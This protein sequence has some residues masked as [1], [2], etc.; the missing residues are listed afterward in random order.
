MPLTKQTLSLKFEKGLN[1][2]ASDRTL[3]VPEM[4]DIQNARFEKTGELRRRYGLTPEVSS[5]NPS[6]V[7]YSTSLGSGTE[8][9]KCEQVATYGDELLLMDGKNAYGKLEDGSWVDKGPCDPTIVRND[10]LRDDASMVQS[11]AD[12]AYTATGGTGGLALMGAAYYEVDPS[13][14]GK[15]S[16]TDTLTYKIY[17]Q[18]YDYASM[19]EFGE[20]LE[21]AEYTFQ[22][23]TNW[24]NER[25]YAAPRVRLFAIGDKFVVIYNKAVT[26]SGPTYTTHVRYRVIDTGESSM[27]GS[28]LPS[29]TTSLVATGKFAAWDACAFHRHA[30]GTSVDGIAIFHRVDTGTNAHTLQEY[31]ISGSNTLTTSAGRSYDFAHS[32]YAR[33]T[34]AFN[35]GTP[36]PYGYF[37]RHVQPRGPDDDTNAIYSVGFNV[38]D[39]TVK[40]KIATI[41]AA[42]ASLSLLGSVVAD[43]DNKGILNGSAIHEPVASG[44]PTHIRLYYTTLDDPHG[45]SSVYPVTNS[46]RSMRVQL[47]DGAATEKNK[48]VH[49]SGL[50]SDPWVF[51][52][53]IYYVLAETISPK[54]EETSDRTTPLFTTG[55]TYV[56]RDTLDDTSAATYKRE[57]ASLVAKTNESD[58][59]VTPY[60]DWFNL[61]NDFPALANGGLGYNMFWGCSPVIQASNDDQHLIG[62]S[63]YLGAHLTGDQAIFSTSL[64]TVSHKPRRTL[65][66]VEHNEQLL[67]GGG[68]LKSYSGHKVFENGFLRRPQISND[69]TGSTGNINGVTG[70]MESGTYYYR[71]VYEY[72]DEAGNLHR[73]APSDPISTTIGGSVTNGYRTIKVY[74]LVH[75]LRHKENVR[76]VLYRTLLNQ[77]NSFRVEDQANDF[78][79]LETTFHDIHR[80]ID[81]FDAANPEAA[82]E[83]LYTAGAA[84]VGSPGSITDLAVHKNRVVLAQSDDRVVVTKPTIRTVACEPFPEQFFTFTEIEGGTQKIYGIES[85]GDHLVIFSKNSLFAVSGEGPDAT[86]GGSRFSGARLLTKGQGAVEG[87]IHENTPAGIIYQSPRG[88]YLLKRGL[89]VDYVGASVEDLG[90]YRAIGSITNDARH[91]VY[92]VLGP[93][94]DESADYTGYSTVLVF[95]YLFGAWTQYTYDKAYVGYNSPGAVLHQGDI[96]FGRMRYA[97]AS[98]RSDNYAQDS[99]VKSG[100]WKEDTS[101]YWDQLYGASPTYSKFSTVV[102]SPYIHTNNLQGAQR[103]YKLQFLGEYLGD[104]DITVNVKVDYDDSSAHSQTKTASELTDKNIY[105]VHVKRQRCRALKVTHTIAPNSSSVQTNGLF[106]LAGMALEVG[107]RP[108]TFKL[109]KGDTI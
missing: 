45:A 86:G 82:H 3:N 36:N 108:T 83:M 60:V 96:Y 29:S 5:N 51:N 26:L 68:F 44:S 52:L 56:V 101:S 31:F 63:S 13:W 106:K 95:N 90:A 80:D 100:V 91:E 15:T 81:L 7:A 64:L 67:I 104:H 69:I 1:Q 97:S 61:N 28:E 65:P 2:K 71:A 103:V 105:R 88:F 25:A 59:A 48:I 9:T 30:S 75:S 11:R 38:L 74:N 47:S 107:F 79:A 62:C 72:I 17:V 23:H 55:A 70:R 66:S 43:P 4:A 22:P 99:A 98:G 12:L 19:Q 42:G 27:L 33:N 20:R 94:L 18:L 34:E 16:G 102:E 78:D 87:T 93:N 50:V 58:V 39:S 92:L 109:P 24:T 77:T 6:N 53:Q 8:F 35:K 14:Q 37:V 84:A 76:I 46:I 21:I 49:N 57:R 40:G 89:E 10:I 41:D 54:A 73:S 32:S 85:T